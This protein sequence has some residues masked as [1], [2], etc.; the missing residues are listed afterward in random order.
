MPRLVTSI[1]LALRGGGRNEAS[2][3]S[4]GFGLALNV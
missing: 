2:K 1:D 4:S 3:T